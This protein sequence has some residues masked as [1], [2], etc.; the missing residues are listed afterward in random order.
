MGCWSSAQKTTQNDD[1]YD[2][3]VLQLKV[4]R[5]RVKKYQSRLEEDNQREIKLAIRLAKEGKKDK[6][7]MVIKA[8]KAREVMIEKA[9]KM[10]LNLQ[11]QL[12]NLE[13]AR[14]TREF[15]DSMEQTNSVLKAMN[16]QLTPEMVENL[17]DEFAEQKEKM[18]EVASLLGQSLDP[19]ADAEAE[20][21]FEKLWNEL[22]EYEEKQSAKPKQREDEPAEEEPQPQPTR[23][24]R[25]MDAALA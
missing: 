4:N 23:Q 14:M 5:D 25:V 24:K 11:E 17:M 21:E 9:D 10:L 19:T 12:N 2:K 3:A 20:Q 18:D 6:A 22:D 1:E 15:Y 7:R 13:Q 16:E 8:K